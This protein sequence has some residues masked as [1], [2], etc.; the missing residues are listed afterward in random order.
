MSLC[1]PKYSDFKYFATF[2][3][4]RRYISFILTTLIGRVQ[5]GLI[6]VIVAITSLVMFSSIPSSISSRKLPSFLSDLP[7]YDEL[8]TKASVKSHRAYR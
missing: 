5:K 1:A 3:C 6:L 4:H 2:S 8:F 7:F